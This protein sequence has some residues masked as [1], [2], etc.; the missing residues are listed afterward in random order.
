MADARELAD[1]QAA[2]L[3]QLADMIEANPGLAPMLKFALGNITDFVT[4]EEGQRAK[5][6]ALA[7]AGTRSGATVSKVTNG[8]ED[9]MFGVRVAFGPV[10]VEVCG[11]RA[12]VCERVVVGT[13]EVTKEVPD[14]EALKSVPKVSVT[15]VV[16]D[17]EWHCGS[18]L[19][20]S[21]G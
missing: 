3:R 2:G 15:E 8:V 21:D 16:E 1:G 14:P 4:R 20:G 5:L 18:L 13:R 11:D 17:V 7:R 6:A 10:V 9:R 12:E 19:G